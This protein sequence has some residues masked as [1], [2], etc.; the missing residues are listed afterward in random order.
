MVLFRSPTVGAAVNL[1]KG[2]AG[3]NG[4]AL[5]V[6][7]YERIGPLAGWLERLGVMHQS[8]GGQEFLKM[9]IAIPALLVVVMACPN[10]LQILARYEPAIGA[11]QPLD[12]L[13][14]RALEW[15][16]SLAWAAGISAIAVVGVL[17]LGGESEFLY[18]Q[19]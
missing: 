2:M 4:V 11:K 9:A 17:L 8:W 6:A 19:F 1:L 5:P 18:W 13:L 14:G 10:T 7:I 15:R 16:P 3:L 12:T